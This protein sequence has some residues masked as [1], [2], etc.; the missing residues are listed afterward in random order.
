MTD[1]PNNYEKKNKA[2]DFELKD[3]YSL[4]ELLDLMAFLRSEDGCPWD[5]EQN[6]DS[7]KKNMLEEAYEAIDAIDSQQPD[8]ICDELGDVLMQVVFHAQMA[9]EKGTF[10]FSDVVSGICK[11]L[12]S[13]HTHIFGAD[14]G[15]SP[16]EV[17]NLWEEHKK[18]EKGLGSHSQIINDVPKSLPA[19][20]RSYKVQQKAAKAGFD[21]DNINGPIEKIHEELSEIE[22]AIKITR[23]QIEHDTI[24]EQEAGKIIS[25]E[26]GDLLFSI[27]NYARH[28]N[29]QPEIALA[30]STEKFISRFMDVEKKALRKG[31]KLEKMSLQELDMLWE[32]VKQ[33]KGNRNEIR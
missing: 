32:Q 6:H 4:S 3:S 16:E 19:L 11:K 25:E 9:S 31:L 14:L 18:K 13:R 28:L 17:L 23:Q 20:Q 29:V 21:W 24:S 30:Q 10:T 2:S 33:E 12:I 7:I 5:R 15:N 1:N 8:R 27:V 26:V 22:D